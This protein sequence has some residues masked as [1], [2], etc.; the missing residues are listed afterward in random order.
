MTFPNV[1]GYC[2]RAHMRGVMTFTD[3]RLPQPRPDFHNR[4]CLEKFM[5][6]WLGEKPRTHPDILGIGAYVPQMEG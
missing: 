5:R 4:D 3:P 6:V 2:K 1:C